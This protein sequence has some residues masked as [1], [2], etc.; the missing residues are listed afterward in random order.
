MKKKGLKILYFIQ[1][2]APVHGVSAINSLIYNSGIINE[3]IDKCL[4]EVKFSTELSELRRNNPGKIIRFLKLATALRSMLLKERPDLVYFSLMPV[5]KGFWRDILFV[6]ILKKSNARVIYH[7]H[8]RGMSRWSGS[9]CRRLIYRYVFAGSVVIHLSEGLIEREIR[10]FDLPG[11]RTYAVANGIHDVGPQ[12]HHKKTPGLVLLF[13]SNF[14]PEKGIYDALRI[15]SV[16]REER[17]D[18]HLRLV[19]DFMRKKHRIKLVRMISTMGL[20]DVVTV[21]GP[22][23]GIEKVQEY[24]NADIFIFPS[25]FRQECFPLVLL[26]AMSCSLPV[27]S[28]NIGA[29]PEILEDKKEGILLKERDIHGFARE[30]IEL[31]ESQEKRKNL[32]LAARK[33]Y[34][35]AYTSAH[36]EQKIRQVFEDLRSNE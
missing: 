13:L 9:F 25:Y 3:G 31:A 12:S 16:I 22:K 5:G 26:E 30:I 29:I 28:S 21:T 20:N 14:L 18:I 4:L 19:G 1:L 32:G 15:M 6:S 27:V 24:L 8:N 2:P 10:P 7:L 34:E 11:V 36:F 35:Q 23:Y 33:K 17:R